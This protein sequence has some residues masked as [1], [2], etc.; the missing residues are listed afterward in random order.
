[1]RRRTSL[2]FVAHIILLSAFVS[3]TACD[4]ALVDL[5]APVNGVQV[6]AIP[7]SEFVGQVR[8][9][10]SLRVRV[11]DGEGRPVRSAAVKYDVLA[12]S[13][14]FSADSTLTNDQ[15]FT[16]VLFLPVTAG[17]VIVE[18]RSELPAGTGS[19]RFTILVF[20]DPN[21]AAVFEAVSGDGQTAPAGSVLPEPLVVRVQNPDGFPVDSHPVTFTV[22]R[23]AGEFAGVSAD[24][25][26]FFAGQVTVDTDATGLARAF[27]LLGTEA[28]IHTVTASAAI[29]PAGS[30]TTE[31]VT[32]TAQA[33]PVEASLLVILS[34]DNQTAVIDTLHEE[35]SP[36]F[37]GREPN[38][39]VVQALDPFGTP[40]AGVAVHWR[41]S[42][43]GG[44]LVFAI[45]FTDANGVTENVVE[46]VTE[47]RN[48]I[49]AFAAGTNAVE[50]VITGEVLEAPPPDEGGGGG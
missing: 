26:G 48:A 50:F 27:L 33:T 21:E 30:P 6:I 38:P 4:E 19:A 9:P 22:Q 15:G 16:E 42:D 35:D 23:S 12:G 43:G 31:T 47:G 1:M 28:G 34:G 5:P 10:A 29:G 13:G 49:V 46:D 8:V 7:G 44:R 18:A 32:F 11:L 20:S 41:V 45:T 14:V 37:R 2:R 25:S 17:T 36:D 40:V 3:L 39:L 24:R